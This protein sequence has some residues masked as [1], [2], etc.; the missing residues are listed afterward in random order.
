LGG[1]KPLI[2]PEPMPSKKRPPRHPYN[3][4]LKEKAKELRRQSTP[5]EKHFW[6]NLRKMPFYGAIIELPLF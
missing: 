5:A 3:S 6:N 1:F 4:L 2:D